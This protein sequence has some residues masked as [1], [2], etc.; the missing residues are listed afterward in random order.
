LRGFLGLTC[1]YRK[2]VKHYGLIAK[3]LTHL[4]KKGQ[5]EWSPEA[6]TAFQDLK[7]AMSSTPVLGLPNFVAVFVIES[8][9][10]DK[11]IWG[12]GGIIS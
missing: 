12:G 9:A 1:Y 8:D 11:G 7:I 6:N 5:F 10:S 4:L 3:N 2:F